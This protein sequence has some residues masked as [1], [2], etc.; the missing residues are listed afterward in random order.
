M[1]RKLLQLAAAALAFAAAVLP[2]NG[3]C[4][5]AAPIGVV[6][7]HGKGG[8]P[9]KHVNGLASAL[10]EKGFLVANLDMPWSARRDY[11]VDVG[12]AEGELESALAALRAKGARAVFVAGHSQ[13]GVFAL[14]FASRHAVDGI[15][16]IAPG[17]DVSSPAF[18]EKLAEPVARARQLVAEGK[19]A[20]KARFADYEGAKGVYP[21]VTTAASYLSWFDPDGAMGRAGAPGNVKPQVPVLYIAPSG[22]Y[23]ALARSKQA[24]FAA[25]PRNPLNRLYEPNASHIG[26]PAASA[27]EIARWTAEVSDAVR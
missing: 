2:L 18:V 11:D 13:G 15:I 3:A 8:S 26:A 25:L 16:A 6:I 12:A 9:D 19:G 27:D 22:D 7:M 21:V 23:P 17:G 4:A 5:G 24:R 10:A 1:L 20:E 14:Y